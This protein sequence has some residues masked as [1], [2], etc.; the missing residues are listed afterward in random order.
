MRFKFKES[1]DIYKWHVWFAWYPV[2]VGKQWVWLETV[3]RKCESSWNSDHWD[4]L[5]QIKGNNK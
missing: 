5:T 3:W 2:K 1:R 4:Y